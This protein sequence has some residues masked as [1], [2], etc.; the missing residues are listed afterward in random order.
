[1]ASSRIRVTKLP[2]CLLLPHEKTDDKRASEVMREILYSGGVHPL[3]VSE[4]FV[5][6][7][8]HHR[9]ACMKSLGVEKVPVLLVDYFGQGVSV[10]PRRAAIPVSKESVV[11]RAR[12]GDLYPHK[13]TRH[14]FSFRLPGARMPLPAG[15]TRH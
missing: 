7:D 14:R 8:G 6:L 10:E 13:T 12:S 11:G 9:L 5:V 1:M 15:S 2:A 3:V 4:D